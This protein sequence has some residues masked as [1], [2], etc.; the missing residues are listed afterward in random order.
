MPAPYHA[1]IIRQR[2]DFQ[3]K[4]FVTQTR[5]HEGKKYN[6]ILGRLKGKTSLT[7]HSFHYD[8]DVWTESAAQSHCKLHQGSFEAATMPAKKSE[9]SDCGG[10]LMTRT[11]IRKRNKR[12]RAETFERQVTLDRGGIDAEARTIPASLSSEVEVPRWFGKE[13]LVHSKDAVDLSRAEHGLPMTFNHDINTPIG[14]VRDLRLDGSRLVGIFHFSNNARANEIWGDVRDGFIDSTSITYRINRWEEEAGSDT[15]K[16]TS[17]T[18]LEAGPVT[19]PADH[20][21]GINRS[22]TMTDDVD[23]LTHEGDEGGAVNVATFRKDFEKARQLG[24]REGIA[25][26]R[27]RIRLIDEEFDKPYLPRTAETMEL[28]NMCVDKGLSVE[29]TRKQILDYIGAL[30]EGSVDM[31]A[32]VDA[33]AGE[34]RDIVNFTAQL[35]EKAKARLQ[36]GK[37]QAGGAARQGLGQ[38]RAELG[39]DEIDKFAEGATDALLLRAGFITE[40]E[41]VRKIRGSGFA[42]YTLGEL[43]RR[44]CEMRGIQTSRLDKQGLAGMAFKRLGPH[45]ESDFTHILANV[46]NKSALMGWNQ[47]PV[48]WNRW[49][50]VGSLSDFKAA[51]I[52]GL[53]AFTDLDQI[54]HAGGPYLH[55]T[56]ADQEESASL[57]TFG[58]LFGVSRRAIINDDLNEF[59]RTP[60]KMGAAAARKVNYLAYYVLTG[61]ANPPV[62]QVMG[63]DTTALF[64]TSSH[65]N[66][67]TSGGAAPSVTTLNT[68]FASMA[69]QKAPVR[70]G[71]SSNVY[72]NLE[73]AYLIV[74]SALK[75]TAT[76]LVVN[77]YDPAGTA[78]T[79]PRNPYFQRL[80]VI[81]DAILDAK[82]AKGT[83]GWYLCC[84]RGSAVIDTVTMFFLDGQQEP[85]LEEQDQ[86]TD[87]GVTWK[88]R[89]DAVARALDHRGLYYNDG[90]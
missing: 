46:A 84:A 40:V 8:Q 6:V 18:P 37:P 5:E 48:T 50:N 13:I 29:D 20:S 77:E 35:A 61:A 21:V 9:C 59:T 17:W 89:I 14:K 68:A 1:C 90:D 44:H 34:S 49:C 52:A 55:G 71:D 60:M 80:E 82:I 16:V 62:G 72:L 45:T 36:G 81:S 30:T 28:R 88:V 47:A 24:R 78:G 67:V 76:A 10:K 26:D 51:T 25:Q 32:M 31:T 66:Y 23:G 79:L 38:G 15:V 41:Q 12:L 27:A 11:E 53:S 69:T 42:S 19:I 73:P 39:E 70:T 87:D 63:Y 2:A 54:P 83:T 57:E 22:M 64:D 85:Y 56:M 3:Q 86:F 74:P 33:P 65:A 75:A 7:E 43:V 4:S 58:K